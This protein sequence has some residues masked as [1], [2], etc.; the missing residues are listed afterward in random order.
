M[1]RSLVAALILSAVSACSSSSPSTGR[2]GASGLAGSPGAAGDAGASGGGGMSG[3]AG[4]AGAATLTGTAGDGAALGAGGGASGGAGVNGGGGASGA[5]GAP[6]LC[7]GDPTV[8]ESVACDTCSA[9]N[10]APATDGCSSIL[11]PTE[12]KRRK[13]LNLYC[14]LRATHCKD[15]DALN[16]WCGDASYVD[17]ISRDTAADGPCLNEF[18]AAAESTVAPTI[19]QRF[20]DPHYAIGGAVNLH[21]CRSTFCSRYSDPPVAPPNACDL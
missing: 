2:G 19:K 20:I 11:F 9:E 1:K 4:S 14:C 17:C 15:G 5:G 8:G 16:C 10:C 3:G 18:R 7:V 12:E 6:A 13:C 21:V